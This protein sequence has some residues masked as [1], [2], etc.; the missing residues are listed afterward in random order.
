MT[1]FATV[2][3]NNPLTDYTNYFNSSLFYIATDLATVQANWE[4]FH[5]D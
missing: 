3:M 2:Y 4:C 5:S 1:S